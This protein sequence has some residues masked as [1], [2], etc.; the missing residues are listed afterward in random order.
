M[1]RSHMVGLDLCRRSPWDN[2]S[3]EGPWAPLADTLR[4]SGQAAAE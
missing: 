2:P 3:A 4:S 1:T